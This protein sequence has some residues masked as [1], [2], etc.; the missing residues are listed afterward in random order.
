MKKIALIYMGGTFGCI[1]EPLAPMPFEKFLPLLQQT[2]ATKF[3]V[4]C[5]AAPV[6]KDSSACTAADWLAL[7][8]QIQRL[9]QQGYA[10]FVVIHG[11]DTLSY[12]AATL[13]RFLGQSC[14]VVITGSQYALL[15]S[16]GKEIRDVTDARDNLYFALEQVTI[17]PTGCYLAFHQQIF[18]AQTALKIHTTELNAFTGIAAEQDCPTV[19]EAQII[20]DADLISCR[21][22]SILNIMAQPVELAAF[23]QQLHNILIQPPHFLIIQGFGTG[24]LAVDASII[25]IFQQLKQKSCLTILNT[26]VCFGQIDQRYAISEWVHSAKI[27]IN[28]TY[29]HADLYA[30]LLQLYLKF[31][32]SEQ[33]D[34]H[35]ALA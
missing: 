25:E 8:Q 30:K 18:H 4:D 32:T 28:N 22:L 7:V 21:S 11:T 27:L 24:N 19:T 34:Q 16:I 20:S 31:E 23:K 12:A 15:D 1:G 5:V 3:N 13:A 14:H 33:R 6:I 17:R 10:H 26:Q 35:W 2:V 9:Q 29:G